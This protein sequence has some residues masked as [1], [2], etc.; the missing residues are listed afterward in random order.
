[1]NT[2]RT[3][4]VIT[5]QMTTGS[6]TSTDGAPIGYLRVGRGPAVMVLHGSG[7]RPY[8]LCL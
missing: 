5:G 3:A 7:L 4:E 2:S 1:M 8:S 6:V